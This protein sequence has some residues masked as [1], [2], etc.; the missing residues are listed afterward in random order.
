VLTPFGKR[1]QQFVKEAVRDAILD[2]I[3]DVRSRNPDDMP[4]MPND[5][6]MLPW[7]RGQSPSD[8]VDI[9]RKALHNRAEKRRARLFVKGD[10]KEEN[11]R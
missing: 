8:R 1:W 2:D 5:D 9:H 10:S 6:L 11:K 3:E 4:A 7:K